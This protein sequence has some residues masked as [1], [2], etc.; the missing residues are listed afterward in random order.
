MAAGRPLHFPHSWAKKRLVRAKKPQNVH[1]SV[2]R[3]H[4]PKK[5][6]IK[7]KEHGRHSKEK[8]VGVRMRF[9]GGDGLL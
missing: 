4:S 2:K 9:S 6:E 5:I 1:F 7:G 3:V 8:A